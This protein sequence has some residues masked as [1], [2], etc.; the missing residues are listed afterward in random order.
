[1]A[2]PIKPVLRVDP[3]EKGV[4]TVKVDGDPRLP[5]DTN[6]VPENKSNE[7][8][9]PPVAGGDVTLPP[10]TAE[11]Q[12]EREFNAWLEEVDN[13]EDADGIETTT[14]YRRAMAVFDPE[15]TRVQLGEH[16]AFRSGR[17]EE[18]GRF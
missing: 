13:A 7:D 16:Y 5:I 15:D 10:E 17:Y 12:Y 4:A 18:F 8:P 3:D 1:M 14:I 6:A 2:N 9:P 11:E